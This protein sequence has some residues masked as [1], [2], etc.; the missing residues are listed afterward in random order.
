MMVIEW[1]ESQEWKISFIAR[2]FIHFWKVM[3]R[4]LKTSPMGSGRSLTARPVGLFD[5][6]WMIVFLI[7]FPPKFWHIHYERNWRIFMRET[8]RNKAFLIQKLN[9]EVQGRV[10]YSWAFEWI[11]KCCE[12]TILYEDELQALLLLSSLPGSWKILMVSLSNSTM[13]GVVTMSSV[14]IL[15]VKWGVERE[16][17]WFF[18]FGGIGHSK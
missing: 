3:V 8:A 2:I 4:S 13:D 1:Y 11:P 18:T 17:S 14:T 5:N 7:M 6:G 12:P 10:F 15:F 16:R 9:C